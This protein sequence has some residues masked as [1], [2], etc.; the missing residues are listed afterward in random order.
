MATLVVTTG[1]VGVDGMTGVVFDVPVLLDPP[2]ETRKAAK[3]RKA[4]LCRIDRWGSSEVGVAL[5]AFN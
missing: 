3:A 1:V 5:R 4:V 2:Q